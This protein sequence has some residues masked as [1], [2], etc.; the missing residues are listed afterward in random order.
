VVWRNWR[1]VKMFMEVATNQSTTSL[2]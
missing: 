2:G 1:R